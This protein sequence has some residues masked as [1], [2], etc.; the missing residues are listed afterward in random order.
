M[1]TVNTQNTY[2]FFLTIPVAL[3]ALVLHL[4]QFKAM[5]ETIPVDVHHYTLF[6]YLLQKDKRSTFAPFAIVQGAKSK[7][8]R[9]G[10]DP[11]WT[12]IIVETL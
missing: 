1:T 8:H 12:I 7:L 6:Q 4:T 9:A 11:D 10:N 5:L 2:N 3:N